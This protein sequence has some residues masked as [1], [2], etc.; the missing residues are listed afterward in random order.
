[1]YEHRR[2]G[3]YSD[4][5]ATS[6]SWGAVARHLGR[7]D[8][9]ARPPAWLSTTT[10]PARAGPAAQARKPG[11]LDDRTA[12]SSALICGHLVPGR[13]RSAAAPLRGELDVGEPH[14]SWPW[15]KTLLHS[16]YDDCCGPHAACGGWLGAGVGR[17]SSRRPSVSRAR[18]RAH[19]LAE[20]RG[21]IGAL[22]VFGLLAVV[23][24]GSWGLAERVLDP[25]R[26]AVTTRCCCS[27]LYSR[28][29]PAPGLQM[30]VPH[31]HRPVMLT[32]PDHLAGSP[33]CRAA[34]QPSLPSRG[35]SCPPFP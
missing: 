9:H 6:R 3:T 31:L 25:V 23:V 27:W 22:I 15:L 14:P 29:T 24:Y 16:V 26:R 21:V 5:N 34:C 35:S 7:D 13:P 20:E 1:M 18:T 12:P 17:G 19:H 10:A 33:R 8:V 28:R 30:L 11:L 4:N 2:T 32:E